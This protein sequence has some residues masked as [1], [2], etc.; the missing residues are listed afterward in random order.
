MKNSIESREQFQLKCRFRSQFL[1]SSK[2]IPVPSGW[3]SWV[4]KGLHLIAHPD[5]TVQQVSKEGIE[6]TLLGDIIDPRFPAKGNRQI[7]EDL[8]A[9]VSNT[10]TIFNAAE[11][12]SGRWVLIFQSGSEAL[13]FNDVG[14]LRQVY[15]QH[16]ASGWWIGSQPGI[17]QELGG[18]NL[19]TTSLSTDYFNSGKGEGKSQESTVFRLLPNHVLDLNTGDTRRFWPHEPLG[20]IPLES[21]ARDCAALLRQQVI[22]AASRWNLACTLTSGFDSRTLLGATKDIRE[23]VVFYTTKHRELRV[24][25]RDIVIPGKLASQ[26]GLDFHVIEEPNVI[27]PEFKDQY[28]R[29]VGYFLEAGG[30]ISRC[31]TAYA[32]YL[33]PIGS[34]VTI[35][36]TVSE[37][38]KAHFYSGKSNIKYPK[39]EITAKYLTGLNVWWGDRNKVD[40]ESLEQWLE[41]AR[42]VEKNYKIKILDLF[43]WEHYLGRLLA[44]NILEWDIVSDRFAPY[45]NRQ[46]IKTILSVD[47][48][49]RSHP[50]YELSRLISKEL[51]PEILSQP[52]NP[53][54]FR[55]TMKIRVISIITRTGTRGFVNRML[56]IYNRFR[57]GSV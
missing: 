35:N 18:R 45:G 29:N 26:L 2:E 20:D 14:G 37:L 10:T 47:S 6:L 36:G 41:A 9:S 48:R 12:M 25:D 50:D 32:M 11:N 53:L 33:D 16:L 17:L 43:Y 51:W 54:D 1:L 24:T 52:I 49:Y 27:D 21:A 57:Y 40:I 28:F 19:S 15:Y 3:S 7:L 55:Q 13:L 39:G 5:L 44:T 4:V 42:E 56:N 8:V 38:G 23:K 46:M 30:G 22:A 34:R 31:Y